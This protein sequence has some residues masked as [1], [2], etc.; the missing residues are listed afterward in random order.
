MKLYPE[1]IFSAKQAGLP[2]SGFRLWFVAKDYCGGRRG[3]IPVKEFRRYLKS[4]GL[5]RSTYTRWI[6]E[7]LELGLLTR[8][9]SKR[10][11]LDY[12]SLAGWFKGA[13]LAGCKRLNGPVAIELNA[14]LGRSWI[15][16][17]WAG[18]ESQ[19]K[20][21]PISRETLTALTGAPKSTQIYREK[22]AGVIQ[23]NNIAIWGEYQELA[24]K[25][26]DLVI[27]LYETPG[28]FISEKTGELCQRLPN[29]REIPGEVRPAKKG[30]TNKINKL[31]ALF[32]S[33]AEAKKQALLKRYSESPKETKRIKRNLRK[34][35]DFKAPGAIYE[36]WKALPG[37][38]Q[39][40]A[41]CTL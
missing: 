41:V 33:G 15:S 28:V 17:T 13:T 40:W 21:K 10:K 16:L 14:F 2:L 29:S 34:R 7:A 27:S 38:V 3:T 20:G 35:P 19:F 6:R 26:P 4:L 1:I 11:G 32:E 36:R 22:R 9:R 37:G 24:Q 18:Y 39:G 8:I 31:L 30:R 25:S 5:A 23:K 12:Y